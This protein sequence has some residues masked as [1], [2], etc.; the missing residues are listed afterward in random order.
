MKALDLI[1]ATLNQSHQSFGSVFSLVL[2]KGRVLVF[3]SELKKGVILHI[4]KSVKGLNSVKMPL[5]IKRVNV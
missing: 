5:V 2:K 1:Q 4:A 3:D